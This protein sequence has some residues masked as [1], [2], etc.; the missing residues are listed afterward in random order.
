[1]IE[2]EFLLIFT[3]VIV[4]MYTEYLRRLYSYITKKYSTTNVR[5]EKDII[6]ARRAVD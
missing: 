2:I 6:T 1:V 5:L 3:I 4:R